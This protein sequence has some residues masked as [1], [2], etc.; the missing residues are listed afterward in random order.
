MVIHV[1]IF[2]NPEFRFS[3][4][5]T[6]TILCEIIKFYH[7]SL[8]MMFYHISLQMMNS[9]YMYEMSPSVQQPLSSVTVQAGDIASLTCRI[10]GRP[11]PNISWHFQDTI[12]LN[13]G[14]RI[15]LSYTEEGFATLQARSLFSSV[16]ISA[17]H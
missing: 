14:P 10:C 12:P 11:R 5:S 2:D 9:E 4:S 8:Q 16:V 1:L 7:I 13:S 15:A 17:V 6:S 3:T